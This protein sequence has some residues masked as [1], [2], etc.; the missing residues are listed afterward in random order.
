MV[1]NS[2]EQGS[3]LRCHHEKRQNQSEEM[4]EKDSS[5]A[6]V[7]NERTGLKVIKDKR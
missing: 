5:L 4:L 3:A 1:L 6:D 2:S 7:A